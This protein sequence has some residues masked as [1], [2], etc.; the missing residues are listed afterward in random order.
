[1]MRDY[2][3]VVSEFYRDYNDRPFIYEYLF[4]NEVNIRSKWGKES[5]TKNE[6]LFFNI[7]LKEL[8]E[9]EYRL[10]PYLEKLYLI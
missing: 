4:Y 3:V 5:N 8:K 10:L 9:I 2:C 1:M 6:M 7:N